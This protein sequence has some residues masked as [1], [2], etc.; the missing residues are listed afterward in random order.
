MLYEEIL[1]QFEEQNVRYVLVGGLAVNLLGSFRSTADLDILVDMTDDN[2]G[3]IVAIL[4]GHGYRVK[5]PVDPMGIA[6]VKIRQDWIKNKHMKAFNFYK[7][8]EFKEVDIIIDSPVSF[9][10]AVK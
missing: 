7:E 2:L 6:H 5:Q 3:K 10:D 4:T 9:K 1:S 8:A